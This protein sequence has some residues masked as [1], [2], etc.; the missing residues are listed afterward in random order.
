MH[1]QLAARYRVLLSDDENTQLGFWHD[2]E[3]LKITC[4]R[5]IDS[6]HC[7]CHFFSAL[8]LLVGRQEGYP[9]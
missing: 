5:G 8:T 9:A 6:R 1:F 7:T 4:W 2:L 3:F